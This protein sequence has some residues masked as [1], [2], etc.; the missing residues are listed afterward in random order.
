MRSMQ[1]LVLMSYALIAW[2]AVSR[3]VGARPQAH[4]A[5]AYSQ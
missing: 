5:P 4:G 1:D 3:W 2:W